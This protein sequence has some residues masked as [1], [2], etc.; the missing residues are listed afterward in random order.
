MPMNTRNIRTPGI[1]LCAGLALFLAGTARAQIFQSIFPGGF[2]ADAAR[3]GVLHTRDGGTISVGESQSFGTGG[4]DVYVVKT[5]RCGLISWS[6]TYD[7]G[8]QDHG[9]KIRQTRDGGYI[10]VGSTQNLNSCCASV[11]V[12][13]PALP[14]N[15]IFLLKIDSSGTTEWAKTYGGL[16]NDEGT[17]IQLVGSTGY[18]VSGHT[19]SFGFGRINAYLMRTDTRGNVAWGRTYGDG[20]EY[21]NSCAVMAGGDILAAGASR[22]YTDI[23]NIFAVRVSAT[24][25]SLIWAN[26]YPS[27]GEGVARSI[28]EIFED[29]IAVAGWIAQGG[30]GGQRDGYLARMNGAG[31]ML[32][33]RA[34]GETSGKFNDELAEVRQ[35]PGGSLVVTGFL[36]NAR[37]G[38]GERDLYLSEVNSKLGIMWASVHGGVRNDEGQSL[39]LSRNDAAKQTITAAGVTTSFTKADEDLYLLRAAYGGR[40]GCYDAT[41]AVEESFPGLQNTPVRFCSPLIYTQCNASAPA[42]FNHSQRLLCTSC[43][44]DEDSRQQPDDPYLGHAES[45]EPALHSDLLPATAGSHDAAPGH[46]ER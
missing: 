32:I 3:G 46:L 19:G 31:L 42:V 45:G 11:A 12:V 17:D 35:S 15:D 29:Q 14:P 27:R 39:D 21:F 30:P 10:I 25:G 41:P 36:T 28:I 13:S 43:R 34:Y 38:F 33:D 7:I 16:R 2:S 1:A 40:T 23:E 44:D 22:S 6:A 26:V 24:D 4:Y 5:N 20:A 8:G 37:G 18:I 9:R